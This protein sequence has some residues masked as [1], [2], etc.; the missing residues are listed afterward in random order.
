MAALRGIG[1]RLGALLVAD[2]SGTASCN[3][4]REPRFRKYLENPAQKALF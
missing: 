3:E 4:T 2:L 1:D